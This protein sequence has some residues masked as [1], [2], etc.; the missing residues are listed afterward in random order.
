MAP[1]DCIDAAP[2][3]DVTTAS[4]GFTLELLHF[5]DQEGAVAA[6]DDAPRLSAVLNAL[7]AQDLGGDGLPDNT[8]TL[9][10][11]DAFIPGLFFNASTDAFGAP[12]IGDILIQNALGLQAI[13]FGNHEFDLGTE[14][15][16]GLIAGDVGDPPFGGTA[17][18]YLSTNLDFTT[19]A[20]LG[21]LVVENGG[22]PLANSIT[23]TIVLETGGELIGVVGATTPTLPVISNPG[24]VT[25]LPLDFDVQPTPEQLDALAA[26]IQADVDAL[27]AANPE[28]DKVIL[29][30]HMQQLSIEVELAARLSGVDIIVAGGS[31]TRLFD[32]NDRPRD[33]DSVQGEYPIEAV[34][35]DGNPTLIVN[36]DGSYKYVGRLVVEFDDQGFVIPESYDPE[37]SGAFATDAQGVADL[38][39]EDLVDPT[40]QAVTDALRE[41]IL[42]RESVI[43]GV[44]DVF[45]NGERSGTFTADDPDGVRTQETNLGNLTADAN[46][47]IARET[48]ASVVVSIKNGGGVRA[49]IGQIIVP[50]GGTEAERLP[51]E[52]IP[53]VKPEGGISQSDVETALAFNNGLT[54]LTLTRAELV[55]VLEHGV[56]AL[57]EVAGQFPQVAGIEFSFDPDLPAG[58]RI[59]SA[60]SVD[61]DGLPVDVLVQN[62]A[63]VG[64]ADATLRVV[65]LGFLADGGD[66]YPFPDRDRLDL[67][68][69]DDA[70]RTGDADFAPDGTE[71]D[72]F[73]EY[74]LDNFFDTPFAEQDVGPAFDQ[75]IQNLD[76]RDD[77][78]LEGLPL[79]LTAIADI[80]GASHVSPLVLQALGLA[81]AAQLFADLPEGTVSLAGPVVRTSGVVTAVDSNG[82]YLQDPEGDGDVR[83]SEAIF[84]FTGAAPTVLVGDAIE[85]EAQVS[86]FFPGGADT[87]N[88]PTTQ[89]SSVAEIVVLSSGNALPEAVIIGRAGRVPPSQNIDDDAF[90]AFNPTTAGLDFY[91]SLEGMRVTLQNAQVVGATNDFGEV[92][93]VANRGRDATEIGSRGTLNISEDDFNPERVQID[94]DSGVL[95]VDVSGIDVGDRLG[96]VTG[97]LGYAFGN[98]EI[99]PTEDFTD[100]IVDRGLAPETSRLE[101]RKAVMT[102]ASYNVLNLDPNDLDGDTDVLDF[103]F[104]T[105]ARQIVDA[106]NAP[107]VIALQEIQDN[108]GSVDDGTV[109]A[110]LT[111][112]LLA[113]SID[114]ADDGQLNGSLDYDWIDNPFITDGASGGQPGGNIRTAYLYRADRVDFVEDSLATIGGQGEGEL[115]FDARLP[116]VADFVFN[117]ETVTVVNNHFSSK[118]GSS[119]LFGTRQPADARQ[120]DPTVNGSLDARQAQA[121]AVAAFVG[122][123]LA[124][125]PDARLVVTG[126][127]NEFEFISPLEGLKAAGLEN[128]IER[129]APDDRH[130]FIFDGNAQALDHMLVSEGVTSRGVK[131]DVVHLNT[132]FAA[133][134]F[135]ASD[136]DP[137]L[138]ALRIPRAEADDFLLA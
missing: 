31:N 72:A 49:S 94:P 46:L 123:A 112:E 105:I 43:L 32:E 104:A 57:P 18:P 90:T 17:F 116:L 34:D 89:L 21:P 28:M 13:A 65:T 120:E 128:L 52:A 124:D 33:G 29:L 125:D 101:G 5:S 45:L 99:I 64:D 67:A 20:N 96:D 131:F 23:G 121:A 86:E 126:D 83:T 75:R 115:F 109:S 25:V 108:S 110:S 80:Q 84:V 1:K 59:V 127:F 114:F 15:L 93:A 78:V 63:I 19:D 48:D 73:A 40:V 103:R 68:Q 133:D 98:F 113:R 50:P 134:E 37:V 130:T 47:A 91:E 132:E 11:G 129:K 136:H 107:D 76:F 82:F 30:A 60:A 111:L 106:L 54:L 16:R 26:E 7:R 24:D 6:L 81:S 97:V 42:A 74:L 137:I 12:G 56:A 95:D 61:D 2:A 10:S 102:V 66:G 27:L 53:G 77:T 117:G 62:G 100:Q 41:V 122:D 70:P 51:T 135:R 87:G 36:T 39:A 138:A 58:A 3:S 44:S 69:A 71:Q 118:G 22:A 35:A 119:P 38:G 88:L 9:S 4:T 92:Y 14:L 85:I 8:L 55:A 79:A